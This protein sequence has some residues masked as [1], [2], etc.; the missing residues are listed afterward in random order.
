MPWRS[1]TRAVALSCRSEFVRRATRMLELRGREIR[2]NLDL[3][4]VRV[5]SSE[6]LDKTTAW[7]NRPR[8]EEHLRAV[9]FTDGV[10]ARA[11]TARKAT[12]AFSSISQDGLARL[13]A[14]SY[15]VDSEPGQIYIPVASQGDDQQKRRIR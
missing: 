13:F 7:F 9:D 1:A 12:G 3:H 2:S 6:G 11:R 10:G 4:H 14:G 15:W 5:V 8:V